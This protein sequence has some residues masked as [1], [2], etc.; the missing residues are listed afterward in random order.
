M[1]SYMR[2]AEVRSGACAAS[3]VKGS[4]HSERSVPGSCTSVLPLAAAACMNLLTAAIAMAGVIFGRP[5]LRV[6][7]MAASS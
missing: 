4:I 3:L 7:R 6:F 5:G 2:L 1:S